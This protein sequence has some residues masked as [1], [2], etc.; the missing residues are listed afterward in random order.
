MIIVILYKHPRNNLHLFFQNKQYDIL[1]QE[2]VL[3][4]LSRYSTIEL[5][6]S[7][8]IFIKVEL[9]YYKHPCRS[10]CNR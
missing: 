8:V 5:F 10:I 7:V 1:G 2:N 3:P 9:S 4:I 6:N